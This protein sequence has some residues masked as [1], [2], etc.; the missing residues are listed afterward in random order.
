MSR[1]ARMASS[2][3]RGR[4]S[5]LFSPPEWARSGTTSWV[6][7]GH[8]NTSGIAWP[9]VGIRITQKEVGQGIWG[10][11]L[12]PAWRWGTRSRLLAEPRP[13]PHGLH[14]AAFPPGE[15]PSHKYPDSPHR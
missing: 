8:K 13:G 7:V 1:C 10:R 12:G 4:Q 14:Q 2:C 9:T 15:V 5:L 11:C 6:I 3:W